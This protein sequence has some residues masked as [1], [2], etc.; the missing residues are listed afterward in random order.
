MMSLKQ[1]K[2]HADNMSQLH[3]APWLVFRTPAT[4]P[5]NQAPA[6]TFNAGR[7]AACPASERAEYESGGAVFIS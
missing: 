2:A 7:Y 5:C 4:A 6:N 1:A 3:G